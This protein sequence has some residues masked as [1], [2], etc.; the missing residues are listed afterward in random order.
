M[1][2]SLL[3]AALLVAGP[4]AAQTS[5][6][7][8]AL[9][10]RAAWDAL[11]R[12]QNKAAADIFR[13]ALA[14]D[15]NNPQ[16]HVGAATA[17][18]ADR[19]DEDAKNELDRALSLN[20][21]LTSAL[22]LMGQ[23]LHRRGDLVGAI[24]LYESLARDNPVDAATQPTLD[25]W[26]REFDLQLHMQQTF[27]DRFAVSFEGPAEEALAARAVDSLNGAL[28]RICGV[29]N[30]YPTR[31]IPVVLYTAEQF[32]DI[33]RAPTWAA[34][35]YD[36]TIRVPMRGALEQEGELDRVLA[37]EFTHALV[38]TLAPTAIPTW[39]NEG[40]AAALESPTIDWAAQTVRQEP[41]V[42]LSVLSRS[43]GRFTGGQAKL[44][45]ATSA[46]AVQRMLDDVGEIAVANLI[47]DLGDGVD[48]ETA[49]AHRIQRTF[50]DF[51]AAL[52]Q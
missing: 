32:T 46:L 2:S 30:T 36:G 19:R 37:H 51:Q 12:G 25:R 47:R 49:F 33:T 39:L 38:H 48:F 44:A 23:V 52:S 26:R 31:T 28:E 22:Q 35:A 42:P 41:P 34:A 7:R 16:L 14:S 24:R 27:G 15:P 21:N 13:Q 29:L 6:P 45:Y 9:M 11:A 43:F 5:N 17:A 3:L 18:Y 4:A 20:S 40:L 10:E 8:T 50:D 1:R